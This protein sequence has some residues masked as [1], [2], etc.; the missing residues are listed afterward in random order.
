MK[1]TLF[2]SL[3]YAYVSIKFV[4]LLFIPSLALAATPALEVSGW[5]PY[6]HDSEAIKDAKKHLSDLDAVY[7]FAFSVKEDGTLKDLAGLGESDWKAFIKSAKRKKV[8]IIPTIMWSDGQNIDRILSNTKLR[9]A[10]VKEIA[11]M[12]KDGR[13]DGVDIDYEAKLS[14]TYDAFG[15]FLKELDKALGSKTLACT[16][17]ART[18]PESLYR[19]IPEKINYANDYKAIS[20]YCDQ[21]EIMAYDQ[22]RA[23]LL[24]NNEKKG[25]PYMPV[26]DVDWV[27]KVVELALKD[28]PKEKIILGMPTYGN[29]YQITVAPEWF[30]DYKRIGALNIPDILEVA[31]EYKVNPGRNKAGEMSYTYFATSSPFKLLNVLPVPKGTLKGMEV[32]AKALLFANATKMEVTFNY[33]SYSDATAVEDKI[34]LA[35]KYKLKGVALFKIDGEEDQDIWK[36]L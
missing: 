10:H 4:A 34:N 16:I 8:E 36:S 23:D 24:L 9:K 11:D 27:E 13:Y 28:I 12:V 25:Y 21:V 26:S 32:A 7:P 18:P 20:K 29:H 1:K 30:R 35:K 19:V 2:Q 3:I 5:I 22:Q 6:W 33:A 17:E 31:D 14:D 15:V